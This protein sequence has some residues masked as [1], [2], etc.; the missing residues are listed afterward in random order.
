MKYGFY[1]IN[2]DCSYYDFNYDQENNNIDCKININSSNN[3]LE[4]VITIGVIIINIGLILIKFYH[5]D[6]IPNTL[7]TR[8]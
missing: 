6:G 1:F 2:C 5:N 3:V 8:K 7:T 4:Y